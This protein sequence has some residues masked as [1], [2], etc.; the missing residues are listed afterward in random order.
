MNK[1]VNLA[2][3]KVV[4]L[5][6]V[7]LCMQ[8]VV[9]CSPF[10]KDEI[11]VKYQ[12]LNTLYYTKNVYKEYKYSDYLYDDITN[13]E[14]LLASPSMSAFSDF[15]DYVSA[16]MIYS[17][18]MQMIE[19]YHDRVMELVNQLN[20]SYKEKNSIIYYYDA[21]TKETTK[22]NSKFATNIEYDDETPYVRYD[23]NEEIEVLD[24]PK[25]GLSDIIAENY[26]IN[27]YMKLILG[28]ARKKVEYRGTNRFE[29]N[30]E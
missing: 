30:E 28:S 24:I 9:A 25:C 16:R 6:L 2:K 29:K 13:G 4:A 8:N 27:A 18:K 11:L 14:Y 3:K 19:K 12:T 10:S 5:I 21:N 7:A 23:E 26:N 15:N 17:R 1:L 20:D 22:L